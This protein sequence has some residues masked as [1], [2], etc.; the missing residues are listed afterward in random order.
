MGIN[1]KSETDIISLKEIVDMIFCFVLDKRFISM[2]YK[3]LG[4]YKE[5]FKK[6]DNLKDYE[7]IPFAR[8][9]RVKNGNRD[10]LLV[11]ST[12]SSSGKEGWEILRQNERYNFKENA[13]TLMVTHVPD[14][15]SKDIF[16]CLEILRK[17]ND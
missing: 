17:L 6:W 1:L 15:F 10:V 7:K 5:E 2:D 3:R 14:F 12:S 9:F 11:K 13:F 16:K 8:I 4:Y